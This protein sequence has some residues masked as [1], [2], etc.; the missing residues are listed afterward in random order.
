MIQYKGVYKIFGD[1][2]DGI[3][4]IQDMTFDIERGHLVAFLGPSGCGKTT[5]LRLTNRLIPL[6]R[7]NIM[8]NEQDIM[9]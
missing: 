2:P 8:I 3:T 5:L 7:G 6:T 9:A 1:G 4:A